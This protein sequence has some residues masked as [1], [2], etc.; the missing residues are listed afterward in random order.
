M[1]SKWFV[2]SLFLILIC[3]ISFT[4]VLA[5]GITATVEVDLSLRVGA[6]TD[7]RLILV[8]PAGTQVNLDGQ[9][10]NGSWVRGITQS[11]H[12]G[13]MSAQFLS[14]DEATALSLPVISREAPITV[15]APG[16][17]APVNDAPAPA[18][19]E[20][21]PSS[22][23]AGVAASATTGVYIRRGDGT[24]Y[25]FA[26]G[27]VRGQSFTIDGRNG[28]GSWVR[29]V[30]DRGVGGWVFAQYLTISGAQIQALPIVSGSAPATAP[31][32]AAPAQTVASPPPAAA[33]IT[34]TAPVSGFSYGG[35]ISDFSDAADNAMRTAGG[36]WYK[37]QVRYTPG[38]D[39]SSVAWMINEA[40]NR[41]FRILLGV[42]GRVPQDLNTPGY[43]EQFASFVGGL[44]GIGADAV[45]VWN[46]PNID[47]EWPAGQIDPGLY[48][49]LLAASYNA[50]K[51]NNPN[52]LVI[53]GAPA[54]TGFFGGC[55]GNGCDD[56]PFIAGMAAAGA[57]NYMDCIGVH[58]NEGIVPP[59]QN[60]G[61]P[62]SEYFTRYYQGM[63]STYYN[64]FGGARP[65]CFTELGYLTGEGFPPLPG[66]FAWAGG[67][68]LADQANWLGQVVD[69]A[70]ASGQVRLL[71]VWNV[72]FSF[73][74]D[75]PMAGYA[76]IRPDG[77]CPACA[78][79]AS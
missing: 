39:P 73:Y 64:A 55:S 67:V 78:A 36:T 74:G 58:Y 24:N 43:F 77:S 79:M 38:D 60:S 18:P 19:A 51:A 33:P 31:V 1:F 75:D 70:A 63:V 50:I 25:N 49:Q 26:G 72:N 27:L 34:S 4:S 5:Q 14:I 32:A 76:I 65:L 12:V 53:S 66:A 9:N 52:T 48:T 30:S 57:A 47:R 15:A 68:S 59:T 54:P 61:D 28:D 62:R 69:I 22:G 45:E 46:E 11:G 42:I 37:K 41:G 10:G 17:A 71:I 35:H 7:W 44:A 3:C 13:W 21:A 6:G 2:V 8:M 16:G 29:G 40:H 56:A 20:A 23:G